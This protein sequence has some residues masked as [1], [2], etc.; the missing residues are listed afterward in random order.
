M[1]SV[2][3]VPYSIYLEPVFTGAA[4]RP[5]GPSPTTPRCFSLKYTEYSGVEAP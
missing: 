4:H 1:V 5:G 2:A 3:P